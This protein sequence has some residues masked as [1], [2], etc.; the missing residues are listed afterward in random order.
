MKKITRRVLIVLSISIIVALPLAI[1]S[2]WQTF[3]KV[4]SGDTDIGTAIINIWSSPEIVQPKYSI[5]IFLHNS[6]NLPKETSS[7]KN[8]EKSYVDRFLEDC[9]NKKKGELE[10]LAMMV[11]HGSKNK[12]QN[13]AAEKQQFAMS[14]KL[15]CECMF[16]TIEHTDAFVAAKN[17]NLDP[18]QFWK[19]YA[20][21]E[22]HKNGFLK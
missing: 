21:T 7:F 10:I 1:W 2:F 17:E 18:E 22:S 8:I 5:P 12:N 20:R 13:A 4:I 11:A 16:D 19:Q 14:A 15:Y 9:V 3:I 6:E